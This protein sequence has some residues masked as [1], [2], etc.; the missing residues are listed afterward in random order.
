MAF[1][2]SFLTARIDMC[3]CTRPQLAAGIMRLR[4]GRKGRLAVFARTATAAPSSGS[5]VEVRENMPP[6]Y[7][8]PQSSLPQTRHWS[9]FCPLVPV[10]HVSLRSC[11]HLA[12]QR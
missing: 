3:L 2:T 1:M 6:E 10:P 5:M 7:Q 8:S 12:A 4:V 9:S 11:A